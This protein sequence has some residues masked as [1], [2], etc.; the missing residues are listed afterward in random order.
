MVE[1]LYF[2]QDVFLICHEVTGLIVVESFACIELICWR[3]M[4]HNLLSLVCR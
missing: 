4:D 1:S 3:E 2:D